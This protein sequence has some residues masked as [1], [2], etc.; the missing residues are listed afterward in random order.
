[1]ALEQDGCV[2]SMKKGLF[3]CTHQH[4]R[5]ETSLLAGPSTS[6]QL[7]VRLLT[8]KLQV[9]APQGSHSDRVSSW[10]FHLTTHR[11]PCQLP[12]SVFCPCLT[13][14]HVSPQIFALTLPG[15]TLLQLA[16]I[17]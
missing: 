1:M 4:L 2:G 15:P 9:R 8:K 16:I 10:L 11:S 7:N 17:V 14:T 13:V 12:F 3:V 5:S 6:T